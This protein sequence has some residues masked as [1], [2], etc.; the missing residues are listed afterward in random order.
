MHEPPTWTRTASDAAIISR[1]EV[2]QWLGVDVDQLRALTKLKQFP[3]P[4]LLGAHT[5]T[6]KLT[7]SSR[8]RVGDVRA[9]MNGADIGIELA[10]P[11]ARHRGGIVISRRQ[12]PPQKPV[13]ADHHNGVMMQAP[14][15]DKDP[16]P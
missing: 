13:D 3:P 1:D 14:Q 4:R 11:L 10:K 6:N 9:W 7:S 5:S 12:R 8:W 15:P 2:L 16:A